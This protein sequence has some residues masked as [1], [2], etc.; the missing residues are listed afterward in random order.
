MIACS[1]HFMGEQNFR[2]QLLC[3]MYGLRVTTA[4]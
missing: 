3:G 2:R 4:M 1:G